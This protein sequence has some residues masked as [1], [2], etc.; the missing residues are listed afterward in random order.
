MTE[1][2]THITLHKNINFFK[3]DLELVYFLW[4]LKQHVDILFSPC[5]V[6]RMQRWFQ[7]QTVG[8]LRK[9][10][11]LLNVFIAVIMRR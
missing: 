4:E 10:K 3:N 7:I 5:C 9:L 2:V 8:R 11:G 6:Q 1:L